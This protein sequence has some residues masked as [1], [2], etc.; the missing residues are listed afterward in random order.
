MGAKID[1]KKS[2]FR[3][4]NWFSEVNN[5]KIPIIIGGV[6]GIGSWL[7]LLLSRVINSDLN[8]IVYDFDFVEEINIAGQLYKVSDVGKRKTEAVSEIVKE[9]SGYDKIIP[10]NSVYGE[11]SLSSP[12][13]FSAFD[14]MK[15]RKDMFENWK[16]EALKYPKSI[17]IDGRLLAEQFQVFFVTPDRI[18]EYEKKYLFSDSEVKDESCSYKQTS[19]FAAAIA[20]KMVQG[21][22][23]WFVKDISQ[24]PFY[25]EEIGGL[26]LSGTKDD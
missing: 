13:M 12:I 19:H 25:Y 23:N 22:T 17:F 1:V 21:F 15:A 5:L 2:R 14:N 6:G 8:I 4:A 10:Q 18:E 16:K 3:D 24:L 20:A 26:F 7:V 11:T 9:L